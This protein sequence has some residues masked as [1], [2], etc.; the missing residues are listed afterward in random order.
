MTILQ[1]QI[2]QGG[3]LICVHFFEILLL[4]VR[5]TPFIYAL[6]IILRKM[7]DPGGHCREISGQG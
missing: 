7:G 4:M 5:N 2:L 1:D 3:R 6:V